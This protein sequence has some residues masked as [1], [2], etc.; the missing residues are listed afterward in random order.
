MQLPITPKPEEIIDAVLDAAD[1]TLLDLWGGKKWQQYVRARKVVSYLCRE[2]LGIGPTET[3]RVL[4]MNNHSSV[5]S[6]LQSAESLVRANDVAF[7][8]VL[9]NARANLQE[10]VNARHAGKSEVM[11]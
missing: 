8:R 10:I 9:E 1:I 11:A 2:V 6:H 4:K 5:F 7:M 3:A